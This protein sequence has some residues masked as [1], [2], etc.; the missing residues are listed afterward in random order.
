[1]KLGIFVLL[2]LLTILLGL[3]ACGEKATPTL[4]ATA[5]ADHA[6]ITLVPYT[7]EEMGTSGVVPEGWVE[8]CPGHFR[9]AAPSTVP[10]PSPSATPLVLPTFEPATCQFVNSYLYDVECGYLV[11]LED[12]SRP[13][14]ATVRL[15]VAIFKSANPD[16]EPDPV[17]YLAGGG[18][19]NHLDSSGYYLHN[20]GY[21]ILKMRDYIMYNQRGAHYNRPA[22]ECPG[23]NDY[24]LELAG[25]DLS[26]EAYQTKK[27]DFFLDCRD[28][29]LDRGIKLDTY[30]SAENAADLNDLRLTLGYDQVNLY[31]TSYGTR[32]A[33]TVLRGFPQ[34]VRSV[35][36]DSVF[37]PQVDYFS[38]YA[39]NAYNAFVKLFESCAADPYCRL[40]YPDLDQVFLQV[41]DDLNAKPASMTWMGDSV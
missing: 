35:I 9:P 3:S 30:N 10:T 8:F 29:L 18:G 28:R 25:Q 17:T 24:L 7:S 21:E 22:L 20:G 33:L 39:V 13:D 12:R 36:L 6:D 41:I 16:P 15:H 4:P 38:E 2:A 19:V 34:G 11:V 1:M 32:L 26:G 27:I 40:T 31:G 14:G 5:T 37:P 23:Y